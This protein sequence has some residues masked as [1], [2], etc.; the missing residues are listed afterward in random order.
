[1]MVMISMLISTIMTIIT[2]MI[3]VVFII[4]VMM[5]SGGAVVMGSRAGR[6]VVC[7]IACVSCNPE[8]NFMVNSKP[9]CQ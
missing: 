2:T 5:I 1:M 4:K 8:A 7:K 6:Q 9:L 3:I